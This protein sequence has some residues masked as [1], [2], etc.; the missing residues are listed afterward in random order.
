MLGSGIFQHNTISLRTFVGY[1]SSGFP[2]NCGVR[3]IAIEPANL[4]VAWCSVE[5]FGIDRFKT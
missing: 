3:Q 1:A 5:E 2:T 4:L